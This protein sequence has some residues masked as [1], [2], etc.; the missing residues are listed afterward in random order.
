M[1]FEKYIGRYPERLLIEWDRF[2]EEK[3]DLAINERPSEYADAEQHFILFALSNGGVDL[4]LYRVNQFKL[5]TNLYDIFI[6]DPKAAGIV[7]NFLSDN[8]F[9]CNC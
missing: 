8:P 6:L 9:N 3:P 5:F 1:L 2:K 4:E 7:F